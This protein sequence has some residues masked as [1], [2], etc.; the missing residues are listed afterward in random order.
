MI[1]VA[2][3]AIALRLRRLVAALAGGDAGNVDVRAGLARLNRVVARLASLLAAVRFV[4]VAGAR[5]HGAVER[6]RSK[7]G[8]VL[9]EPVARDA[10]A[11]DAAQSRF[12][13]A[14]IGRPDG[15]AGGVDL[16]S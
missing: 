7:R 3:V 16:P 5:H 4:R 6:D 12:R 9:V 8:F 15:R 11:E 2:L 10:D 14:E 1:G 13:A